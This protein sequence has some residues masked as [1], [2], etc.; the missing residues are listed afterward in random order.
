MKFEEGDKIIVI[1]TGEY[2]IVIEWIDKKMLLIEVDSIRF[3][4]YADQID[5]PYFNEFSSKKEP[6]RSVKNNIQIPKKEKQFQKQ[7]LQDGVWISFLPVLDKDV[8]DDDVI[9]HFRIFLLNHTHDDLIVDLSI[10]YGFEKEIDLKHTIKAFDEMYLVDLPFENLND[11]PRFDFDF[12][13]DQRDKKRVNHFEVIFKPKPKQVFKLA[14][15]VLK[16]QKASFT[17]NLFETFPNKIEED[18]ID[19]S[20]LNTAG[21]K[22]YSAEKIRSNLPPQRTLIDL[23]ADKLQQVPKNADP[24]E[25]LD[26]QMRAF[27]NFYEQALIH[28]LS[29]ITVIHGIGTGKLKDEI[30][31]SLRHKKEVNSFVNRLHPLYG[32]GATEIW[33]NQ[34]N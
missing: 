32:Y 8:F 11:Q 22:V 4:I 1:A 9:S 20:K 26:I 19:I 7:T 31:E 12:S 16:N 27:E 28:H 29:Q 3:P 5:F 25:I 24:A 21:Y 13:L 15:D 23:H 18:K 2:G 6:I 34:I 30:H 33:L 10:Y 17:F 14:D